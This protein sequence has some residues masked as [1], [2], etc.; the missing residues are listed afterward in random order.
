MAIRLGIDCLA[1]AHEV[2]ESLSDRNR[3]VYLQA[4]HFMSHPFR[5]CVE[6]CLLTGVI[7]S[8][9]TLQACME[10]LVF[11]MLCVCNKVC[12]G[13]MARCC[14]HA[15]SQGSPCQ[16]RTPVVLL[17]L[18]MEH[19]LPQAATTCSQC[20]QH[21]SEF[22]TR[23]VKL[24]SAID[25]ALSCQGLHGYTAKHAGSGCQPST[26]IKCMDVDANTPKQARHTCYLNRLAC[27][28]AHLWR[29]TS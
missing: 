24:L 10:A 9:S 19:M 23:Y 21:Q 2:S 22:C 6:K 13:N 4:L 7:Y 15:S 1:M 26:G 17:K 14:T 3:S 16:Q 25:R 27:R 18:S 12:P 29:L 20:S 28:H 5:S 8:L 11:R